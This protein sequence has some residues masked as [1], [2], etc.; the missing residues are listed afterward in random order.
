MRSTPLAPFNA[1]S[2]GSVTWTSTSSGANPGASVNT[3]TVGRLRSGKMS[4]VNSRHT[5]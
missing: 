4:T 3:V 1:Y 2:S 5:T